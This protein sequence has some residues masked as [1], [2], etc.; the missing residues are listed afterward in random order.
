MSTAAVYYASSS[1]AIKACGSIIRVEPKVFDD[2]VSKQDNPIVVRTEGGGMS[3]NYKYLTTYRGLT[4]HCKSKIELVL[5]RKVEL[6]DARRMSIPD[7]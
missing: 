7:L 6:I 4:F 3:R 1:N 2:I 5:P